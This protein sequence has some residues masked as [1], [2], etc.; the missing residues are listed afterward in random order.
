MLTARLA[1]GEEALLVGATFT[2]LR[3]TAKTQLAEREGFADQ[4]PVIASC[5][6][7]RCF[8]W[9]LAR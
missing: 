1:V 2:E 5:L 9:L 8:G 3:R 4:V 6:V 7:K